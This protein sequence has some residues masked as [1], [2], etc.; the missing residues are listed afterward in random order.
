MELGHGTLCNNGL[1]ELS[2]ASV[3]EYQDRGF[4][5][6][7]KILSADD[8]ES[9]RLEADRILGQSNQRGGA[10]VPFGQSLRLEA[11]ANDGPAADLARRLLGDRARPVKLTI[12]DKSSAANWAVPWHQDVTIAVREKRDVEGFGS[13]SIKEGIPHVQ[14]PAEIFE[15][16]VA[17]RIHLDDTPESNGALRVV[18]GSHLRGKL[19]DATSRALRQE[20]GETVCE[21]EAG[22]AHAMSPLLLH[23]SSKAEHAA[24]RRVVH[25]EYAA[26]ELPGGLECA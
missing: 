5:V 21:V 22:G 6:V 23:A 16:M 2:Q 9:L 12:F 8:L 18:T 26:G 20:F 3:T 1:V 10:R 24:R 7:P 15:R 11:L 19:N 13:W 4:V 14:P 25:V 17:V